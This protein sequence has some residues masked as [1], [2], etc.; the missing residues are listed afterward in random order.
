MSNGFRVSAVILAAGASRRMGLSK[1]LLPW[2]DSSVIQK[3]AGTLLDAGVEQPVVV[4]GRSS[5]EVRQLLAGQPVRWAH[6]P[7]FENSEMLTSLQIGIRELPND[8]DAFLVV[9]GDQP[10]IEPKIIHKILSQAQISASPLLIPSYHMHRGHPWL[11][12]KTLWAELMTLG[13]GATLRQFLN[14]QAGQ[15]EYLNVDTDTVLMDLDTP[16]DY[17]RYQLGEPHGS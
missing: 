17:A 7:D 12:K 6:N 9:L 4:T 10:Q 3:V 11:I 1:M 2:G 15:I 8:L 5:Q 14:R 13:E 16:E